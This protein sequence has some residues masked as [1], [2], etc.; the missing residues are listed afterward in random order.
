MRE[1]FGDGENHV[2]RIAFLPGGA[3]D[4]EGDRNRLRVGDL[5][6]RYQPGTKRAEGVEALSLHP[7]A[8]AVGLP[9]ALRDVVGKT[10]A[11]DMRQGVFASDALRLDADDK[12]KLCLPVHPLGALRPHEIVVRALDAGY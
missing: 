11:G 5:V 10:V 1:D 3:V 12:S 9:I 6:S 7:L 8:A 4:G 2:A